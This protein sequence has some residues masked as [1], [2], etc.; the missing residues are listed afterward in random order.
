MSCRRRRRRC[1]RQKGFS[2][3]ELMIV[4]AIMGVLATAVTINV[5]GYML[6]AK[7]N[8]ARTDIAVIVGALE[9]YRS[10]YSRYPSTEQGLEVLTQPS[11]KFPEPLL[12]KLPPDPWDQAYQYI[13]SGRREF[14]VFSF[15][16]D[17]A[18]GGTGIDADISS[19]DVDQPEGSQP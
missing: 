1:Y 15:G 14:E 11:S 4:I 13:A 3:V 19:N 16:A 6:S 5:R 12:K 7:Q 18:E 2:L 8:A 10:A 9:T 17:M